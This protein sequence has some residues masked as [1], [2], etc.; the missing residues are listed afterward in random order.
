[1]SLL[2]M[3]FVV[4]SCLEIK[5]DWQP[6]S[7]VSI[8]DSDYACME[9]SMSRKNTRLCVRTIVLHTDT[10]AIKTQS[11]FNIALLHVSK[12]K[13]SSRERFSLPISFTVKWCLCM[14]V[15]WYIVI[16][17]GYDNIWSNNAC[18]SPTLILQN[19]IKAV[20]MQW[21]CCPCNHVCGPVVLSCADTC[22]L[23]RDFMLLCSVSSFCIKVQ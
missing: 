17:A 13:L 21:C 14:S 22:A 7:W 3:M 10:N 23:L 18:P 6:P 4:C 11:I 9:V 12:P 19:Y 15:C 8:W 16:R 1:M 20:G 5:S 2:F